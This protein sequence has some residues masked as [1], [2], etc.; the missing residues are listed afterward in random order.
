[1][2]LGAVGLLISLGFL[3]APLAADGQQPVRV[4]RIG[5]LSSGVP[6]SSPGYMRSRFDAFL[7][8]LR[9]LGYVEGQSITIDWRFA[10]GRDDQLPA[11]AAEL[12]RHKVNVIVTTSTPATLAAQQATGM[13]PIVMTGLADPVRSG[14]VKSLARPGGN[15]TGLTQTTTEIY[16]KR[17]QL[18]REAVPGLTSVAILYN[19]RTAPPWTTG[20]RPRRPPDHWGCRSCRSRDRTPPR[21]RGPFRR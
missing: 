4:A 13:I 2:K 6:P 8:G 16:G 5:I 17:L 10:S 15:T 1:M 18:L 7:Q 3:A 20:R 19:P 12:V 11:L 14:L 9:E 21:L